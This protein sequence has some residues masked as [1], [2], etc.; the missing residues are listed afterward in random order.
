VPRS[1]SY[2]L[3]EARFDALP[4]RPRSLDALVVLRGLPRGAPYEQTIAALELF[5][6]PRG[7]LVFPQPVT[8]GRRGRLTRLLRAPFLRTLPPLPRHALCQGAMTVGY[9]E[10]GQ[11]V[12]AGRAVVPWIVTHA[13]AGRR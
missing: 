1:R 10:I 13:A 9:R 6:A 3:V 12:P 2:C 4:F 5:L 11:I 8:D 7:V